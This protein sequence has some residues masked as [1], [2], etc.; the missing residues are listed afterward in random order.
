MEKQMG[1]LKIG[2]FHPAAHIAMEY[3][4]SYLLVNDPLKILESLEFMSLA[5]N[6]M[7]EVCAETLSRYIHKW[8]VSDRY[9]MGLAWVLYSMR[10]DKN[11]SKMP[12]V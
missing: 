7:A 11:A 3:I 6:R 4:K 1:T 10:D 9:I 12:V 8:P 2:E 5:G